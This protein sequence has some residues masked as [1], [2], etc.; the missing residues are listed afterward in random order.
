MGNPEKRMADN[1]RDH[2]PRSSVAP[3]FVVGDIAA[4]ALTVPARPIEALTCPLC[5]G[6]NDCVAAAS[7]SFDPP[8]WCRNVSFS[9]ELMERVPEPERGVACICR[10]CASAR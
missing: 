4:T 2:R 8:C 9:A 1:V 3:D 10:Q 7:G 5:G 6:A